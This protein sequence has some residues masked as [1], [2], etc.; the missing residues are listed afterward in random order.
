MDSS[1]STVETLFERA[2]A[3]SKTTIELSRLKALETTSNVATS[4]VSRLTVIIVLSLFALVLTVGIALFLGE[5][6]GKTYWGFFIVAAVYLIAGIVF[7]FFLHK[8]IRKPLGDL[9][10][11]QALQ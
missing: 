10:I 6:L 5:L 11:K 4:L 7:Y 2:E 9:I 8:W 1:L 3:W